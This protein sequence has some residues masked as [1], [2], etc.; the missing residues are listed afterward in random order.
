MYS[1][2]STI[3]R[4]LYKSTNAVRPLHSQPA[5]DHSTFSRFRGPLSKEAMDQ[6]NSEILRQF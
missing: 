6:I 4:I 1:F 2:A 3:V 5:P